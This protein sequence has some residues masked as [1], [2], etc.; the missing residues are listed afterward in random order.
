MKRFDSAVFFVLLLFFWTVLSFVS[1]SC[2][3]TVLSFV[4]PLLFKCQFC[5]LKKGISLKICIISV[6]INKR[7]FEPFVFGSYFKTL[8][9]ILVS[10]FSSFFLLH[11]GF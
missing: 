2:V 4:S 9:I 5:G 11:Y 8:A 1:P 7:S 6:I 10:D 3:L